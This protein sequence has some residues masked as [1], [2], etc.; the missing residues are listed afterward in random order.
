MR[1]YA[2]IAW[3]LAD[4]AM[5][6]LASLPCWADPVPGNARVVRLI[7]QVQFTSGQTGEQLLHVGD[8]L[9]PGTAVRT[10]SSGASADL[11]LLEAPTTVSAIQ[12]DDT[13]SPTLV[14]EQNVVRLGP[15]SEL[16]IHRLTSTETGIDRVTDTRLDLK[17]GYLFA[18]VK[19]ST[20]ASVFE[21]NVPDSTVN[22]SSG[23]FD[24][25]SGNQTVRLL[26]GG[27]TLGWPDS[28]T[29]ELTTQAISS[30]QQI[31]ARNRQVTALTPAEKQALESLH[32]SVRV[33][34][35]STPFVIKA[36]CT[37]DP[38]TPVHPPHPP[39]PPHP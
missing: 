15:D 27:L 22:V 3:R 9:A 5:L 19:R 11:L 33:M 39:H 2:S 29:G 12:A 36:N 16:V 7:G 4:G 30:G 35:A 25:S 21:V 17:Q 1:I 24:I 10:S 32:R 14:V 23:V 34:M 18:V 26:N 6:V 8:V 28:K 38:V 37:L 13:A 20:G 31:N